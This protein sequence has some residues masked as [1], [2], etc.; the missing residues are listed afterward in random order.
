MANCPKSNA[1][2]DAIWKHQEDFWAQPN[3]QELVDTAMNQYSSTISL[4]TYI[5]SADYA[6]GNYFKSGIAA[7]N[8]ER[9]LIGPPD[10]CKVPAMPATS[11]PE[12]APQ[13]AAGYL[14]GASQHTIDKR[15]YVLGCF[16]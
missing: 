12:A 4:I 3:A 5:E 9:L 10:V 8:I 13:F 1:H 16:E 2:F 7:G 15:D 6:R 11:D 14:F